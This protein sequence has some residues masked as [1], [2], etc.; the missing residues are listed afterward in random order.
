MRQRSKLIGVPLIDDF[1]ELEF[2][3]KRRLGTS[4]TRFVNLPFEV[5]TNGTFGDP[6]ASGDILIGL[7]SLPEHFNC[8]DF[9]LG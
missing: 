9:L 2:L 1:D 4:I 3:N 7:A 5:I 8:H 6:E